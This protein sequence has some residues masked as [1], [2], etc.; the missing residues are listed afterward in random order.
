MDQQQLAGVASD[1]LAGRRAACYK[2]RDLFYACLEK[3][4]NLTPT[5]VAS[6]GLLY[7]STCKKA[8][9]EYEK[10]CRLTWV[11]HFDRQ[12]CAKKRV[13]RFLDKENTRS[14]PITLP[15]PSTFK[16]P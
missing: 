10:N 8:R 5:E 15:E 1:V 14:G 13:N 16:N 2:A 4:K 6:V 3:Q 9:V 12:Y 11:K 7:P